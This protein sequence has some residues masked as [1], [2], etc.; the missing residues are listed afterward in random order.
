MSPTKTEHGIKVK[1]TYSDCPIQ[2][3]QELDPSYEDNRSFVFSFVSKHKHEYGSTD[4]PTMF[5]GI[6]IIVANDGEE[7]M[8]K[9]Y[10]ITSGNRANHCGRLRRKLNFKFKQNLKPKL[11]R[12]L[13]Y[14]ENNSEIQNSDESL[15]ECLEKLAKDYN[16]N[17]AY[18]E[19]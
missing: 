13:Y 14:S 16:A 18:F 4:I 9:I 2:C 3:V 11:S 17:V 7:L 6:A 8:P 15:H 10:G 5:K 12:V 19:F 1:I